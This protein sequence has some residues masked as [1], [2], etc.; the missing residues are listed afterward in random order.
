MLVS[1]ARSLA[2]RVLVRRA[3]ML[4]LQLELLEQRFAAN[5]GGQASAAQLEQYQRGTNSLRRT[6]QALGL[7]R[8]AKDVTPDHSLM[9]DEI[10]DAVRLSP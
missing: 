8:R 2:E 3:A 7:E 1:V 5:D 4:C 10:I 9:L 6:L